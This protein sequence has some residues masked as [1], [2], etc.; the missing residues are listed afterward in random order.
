MMAMLMGCASMGEPSYVDM[1]PRY[2]AHEEN[3]EPA[4]FIVDRFPVNHK[5]PKRDNSPI[6]F[7][8]QKCARE[9][10][11]FISTRTQYDCD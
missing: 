11:N 6:P 5:T 8:F 3:I 2:P 7:Y 4:A 9:V 1:T 10:G